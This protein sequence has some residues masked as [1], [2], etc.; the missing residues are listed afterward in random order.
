M[1]SVE[2][3]GCQ[4]HSQLFT[5][6]LVFLLIA[7]TL[8]VQCRLVLLIIIDG[9]DTGCHAMC[10]KQSS[11]YFKNKDLLQTTVKFVVSV[12]QLREISFHF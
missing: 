11:S 1:R 7:L 9:Y 2:R 5:Q 12:A 10:K 4:D 8:D 3:E 6:M